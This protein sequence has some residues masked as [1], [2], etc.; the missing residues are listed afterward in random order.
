MASFTSSVGRIAHD[1]WGVRVVT[2]ED[3]AVRALPLAVANLVP[4]DKGRLVSTGFC[5]AHLNHLLSS[6]MLDNP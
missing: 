5:L 4:Y 3:T 6:L 2:V 1:P